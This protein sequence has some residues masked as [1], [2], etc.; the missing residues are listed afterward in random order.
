[1]RGAIAVAS[2]LVAPCTRVVAQG[3]MLP[4]SDDDQ[5]C[6][7]KLLGAVIQEDLEAF[8]IV[9]LDSSMGKVLGGSS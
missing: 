2:I 3:H 4:L 1:M 7:T 8:G 5:Q 9:H 6:I